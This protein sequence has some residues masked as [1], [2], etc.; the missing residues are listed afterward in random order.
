MEQNQQQ[1][2]LSQPEVI[3]T[4]NI[5]PAIK[6]WGTLII[7]L[8]L[9]GY[10]LA[11]KF[12]LSNSTIDVL[13]LPP[14][15]SGWAKI[16]IDRINTLDVFAFKY[17]KGKDARYLFIWHV[18]KLDTIH[19]VDKKTGKDTMAVFQKINKNGFP[20]DTAM[21]FNTTEKYVLQFWKKRNP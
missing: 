3:K 12:F 21:E 20:A 7:I 15:D 2:E 9:L 11:D 5:V 14:T 6:K 4:R 13:K 8:L 17:G 18:P 1:P 16:Q 19:Y 10:V